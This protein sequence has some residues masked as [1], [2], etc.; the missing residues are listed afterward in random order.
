MS[1]SYMNTDQLLYPSAIYSLNRKLYE[2][3][4]THINRNRYL[5]NE[6][7]VVVPSVFSRPRRAFHWLAVADKRWQDS[8]FSNIRAA[9]TEKKEGW[10]EFREELS[11]LKSESLTHALSRLSEDAVA[12]EVFK[13]LLTVYERY[14]LP[15]RLYLDG[16]I[17]RNLETRKAKDTRI[18]Y[19]LGTFLKKVNSCEEFWWVRIEFFDDKKT[20]RLPH[21]QCQEADLCANEEHEVT[22]PE[23]SKVGSSRNPAMK[24]QR[25][26]LKELFSNHLP[27]SIASWEH[28]AVL[29]L[30]D[31]R[32]ARESC[33]NIWG[34]L[35]LLFQNKKAMDNFSHDPLDDLM[36]ELPAFSQ[37]L[38]RAAVSTIMGQPLSKPLDLI[39]HFVKQI[40]RLQDWQRVIVYRQKHKGTGWEPEYCYRR[41]QEQ[42][43]REPPLET[44][45][46]APRNWE[47]CGHRKSNVN[48]RDCI[49]WE[50]TAG[51]PY[52]RWDEDLGVPDFIPDLAEDE[53]RVLSTTR[54]VFEFSPAA[55]V[56]KD[57]EQRRALSQFYI[58][59][60]LDVL[61]GLAA[62][63]RARRSALRTAAVAIMG[64]NMSHN[65]G[66]HVLA[67]VSMLPT[68]PEIA[69]LVR[70]DRSAEKTW[71]TLIGAHDKSM[72]ALLTHLQ[73]R[74]DFL[75]EV[76]T[77]KS[78]VSLSMWMY[79]DVMQSLNEQNL[80]LK[81]IT[82]V[83]DK[84]AEVELRCND[85]EVSDRDLSHDLRFASPSGR[86]GA[87]A[88]YA[89]LENIIRN[90]SKHSMGGGDIVQVFVNV[91]DSPIWKDL[92]EV[93]VWDNCGTATKKV[94]IPDTDNEVSVCEY[95]QGLIQNES[96]I[97]DDG[98]VLP[99]NWGMREIMICAAY[100]RGV[101]LE[102]LEQRHT[103]PLFTIAP[104]DNDGKDSKDRQANL[105]YRFYVRFPKEL[106][107]IDPT[108]HVASLDDDK[109]HILREQGITIVSDPATIEAALT[110]GIEDSFLVWLD[111][112]DTT[113]Q[114]RLLRLPIRVFVPEGTTGFDGLPR[115]QANFMESLKELL[116]GESADFKSHS[117]KLILDLWQRWVKHFWARESSQERD[118]LPDLRLVGHENR[119]DSLIRKTECLCDEN[120]RCSTAEPAKWSR[121]AV[122]YDHHGLL[123]H[124][125][126]QEKH[127]N[128]KVLFWEPHRQS[129]PQ[130]QLF[131][132]PP[133]EQF[134]KE[135]L[136]HQL[137]EAA[138]TRV[139]ILD[140]RVQSTVEEAQ[141]EKFGKE[142]DY[143]RPVPVSEL[144]RDMQVFIPAK[145]L[146][147][148]DH[149]KFREISEWLCETRKAV[150]D[151]DFLVVH[152]GVL[153][154]LQRSSETV[155]PDLAKLT[156][157]AHFVVCSGRG[158]PAELRNEP[159]RFVPLS[160][161]LRWTMGDR[162]KYHLC[163]LLF[164]SRRPFHA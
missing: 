88:I 48:C 79:K 106:T 78:F 36:R 77:T 96:I 122:I 55:V 49:K 132:S 164:S 93:T 129:H 103:P 130:H 4:E 160:S 153:D 3:L 126:H 137:L 64:R 140:E 144:L 76:S 73:E 124:H 68:L 58:R 18:D 136:K 84:E 53:R 70:E 75:A 65:L 14:N 114:A 98:E 38:S 95:L 15:P 85:K 52:I 92:Y 42:E 141:N 112:N 66:S 16:I 74:M 25:F 50:D 123:D 110:T 5:K 41:N 154:K 23:I 21:F 40:I 24:F 131:E 13:C 117:Q 45:V 146:C 158:I 108:S 35:V 118:G 162:S 20:I 83:S 119:W 148:L 22:R 151:F 116:H 51:A 150:G 134:S 156:G 81:F 100:L 8:D 91:S 90:S 60:Q 87:H 138:L 163:Q 161:L 29:P 28:F 127:L 86:M 47:T 1:E 61:Q 27:R 125:V 159:V 6:E 143:V 62:K 57:R 147:N 111:P 155:V 69:E 2:I 97:D 72:K 32:I 39:E 82:G 71:P 115:L 109:R 120:A 139:A 33:G 9:I 54:L 17:Y 145:R 44:V 67:K 142:P 10:L 26:L 149:P 102:E 80:L 63:V 121:A 19:A 12:E 34:N 43:G 133:R 157:S 99:R 37:E 89:I 59:Q 101:E 105:G 113:Y 152:Q 11:S 7:P 56:P 94:K 30:Y 104:V 31:T 135:I 128:S 46:T 107:I